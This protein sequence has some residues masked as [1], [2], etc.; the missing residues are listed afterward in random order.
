MYEYRY[1]ETIYVLHLVFTIEN[2]NNC[3]NIIHNMYIYKKK[4]TILI[5]VN[6]GNYNIFPIFFSL[7]VNKFSYIMTKNEKKKC[8]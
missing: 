8:F 3:K 6:C 5:I 4:Y 7:L 2:Y 1:K